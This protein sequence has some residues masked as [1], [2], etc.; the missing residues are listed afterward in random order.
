MLRLSRQARIFPPTLV[1]QRI[2]FRKYSD[3]FAPNSTRHD[4][5]HND[6][7]SK[8]VKPPP[9]PNWVGS[10]SGLW[11]SLYLKPIVQTSA[12]KPWYSGIGLIVWMIKSMMQSRYAFN[13]QITTHYGVDVFT[14]HSDTPPPHSDRCWLVDF[15]EKTSSD[16]HSSHCSP[17]Q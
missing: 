17:K 2:W 7:A 1:H 15:Y 12:N 8:S 16:Q 6:T 11:V 14:S 10:Q 13:F 4:N 3:G 9:E 5:K